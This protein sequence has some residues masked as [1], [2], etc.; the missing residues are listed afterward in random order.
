MTILETP[1]LLLRELTLDDLD[2]LAA[3]YAD[4]QVMYFFDGARTRQQA[5]EEIER[6]QEQYRQIGFYYWA[7]IYKAD[8]CFAGR[9]GLVPQMIDGRQEYG[10][11]YMIARRYW[12]QGLGTEAARAITDYAFEHYSFPRLIAMIA[13][14]NV[15]SIQVAE[16]IG[17]K[18]VGEVMLE[19]Y[20]YP[21][22]LYAVERNPRR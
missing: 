2:D 11:A 18:R 7:A 5:L 16:N 15:A 17:M 3:L 20:T 8:G 9:C 19:W 22:Y 1:R 21:D 6:C 4:P 12:G 13:P 10:L 14:D